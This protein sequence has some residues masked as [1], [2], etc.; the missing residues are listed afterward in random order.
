[1][2][3]SACIFITCIILDGKPQ[4]SIVREEEGGRE[5]LRR[6]LAQLIRASG[7]GERPR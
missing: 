6:S 4:G 2:T 3:S 7:D 1:M 5:A